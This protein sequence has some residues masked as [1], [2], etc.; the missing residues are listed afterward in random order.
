MNSIWKKALALGMSGVMALSLAACGNREAESSEAPDSSYVAGTYTATVAGRNGDITL[1][2]TFDDEKIMEIRH[3]SVET[4]TIGVTAM[5]ELTSLILEHQALGV[6][7]ISGATLTCEAYL[8]ALEDCVTQAGGDVEALKAKRA[9]ATENSDDYV[10][11]ADVIV[12]GA[13]GAGLTAALTA[14][15][16]GVKVVVLEKSGMVGGNTLCAT[17]GINAVQSKVQTESGVN[18]TVEDFVAVQLNN[19]AAKEELVRAL[20]ERSGETIDWFTSLGVE[21]EVGGNNDLM[22][23]ATADGATSVTMV[24]ALDKALKNTD[25]PIY[26]NMEVTELVTAD[27]A[28]VGCVATD[29]DGEQVTFSGKTVILCTGGFGQNRELMAQYRPD[30]ATAITDEI[31]PTTGQGLV[32]AQQVGADAV[33]LDSIQLFP[34][35]IVGYGLLTPNNLPGG[36]GVSGIY[37]NKEAQRFATEGFEISDAILAQPDGMAYCIFNESDLSDGLAK[38]VANGFVV[39]ADTPEELAE[40]LGLDPATLA[41]TIAKWNEDCANGTDTLFGKDG[42][43]ALEGTL[44]GYNFGVGA[45][46]FM[47]GILIDSLGRVQNTDGEAINGLYAAGEVTGG[48]HGTY[49]VDGCG[50]A[51]AFVFGRIAGEA[52]ASACQ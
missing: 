14:A 7:M 37:V 51:D 5:D 25:T 42:G 18:A 8:E 17:M 23:M 41:A 13:G 10:T 19:E 29:A 36:F 3:E 2:V 47:G 24:N 12:V 52:A 27:G 40:K 49:R 45:H 44:Y 34:H 11:E 48:F 16:S 21:F 30:L 28:V 39:S 15:Q 43:T 20:C 22:L 50:T 31:A 46:Y 6:D 32:M 26:L 35:V 1:T 38:L 33:N 9:E 4:E